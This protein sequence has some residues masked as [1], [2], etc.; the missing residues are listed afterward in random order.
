MASNGEEG[1][2][3]AEATPVA[4]FEIG[5]PRTEVAVAENGKDVKE[6][7]GAGCSVDDGAD[8]GDGVGRPFCRLCFTKSEELCPL[9]PPATIPNKTLLHKI[10]DCTTIT[11]RGRN[12]RRGNLRRR[13]KYLRL[14]LSSP[15][16]G[17]GRQKAIAII[18]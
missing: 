5:P 16:D 9:F 3:V 18:I 13:D 6:E 8:S 1:P 17:G 15:L 7:P 2:V 10:F 4:M 12:F 14:G 11:V